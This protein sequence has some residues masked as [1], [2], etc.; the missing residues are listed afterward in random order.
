MDV[1]QKLDRTEVVNQ[2]VELRDL[3]LDQLAMDGE[4]ALIVARFTRTGDEE[5][6]PL[7]VAAFQSYIDVD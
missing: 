1:L 6:K 4:A 3:T 2:V 5:S 7:R